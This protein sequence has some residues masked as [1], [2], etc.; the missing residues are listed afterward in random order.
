MKISEIN[1]KVL[2]IIPARKG[3][4]RI[5]NKNTK[6]FNNVPVIAYSINAAKK[7]KVF[8]YISVST[9]CKKIAKIAKRYGANVDFIRPR[10][11]SNDKA[12]TLEVIKHSIKFYENKG[13]KFDYI[14]C[15]YPSSPFTKPK[16]IKKVLNLLKK[17]STNFVFTAQQF[18]SPIQ[19]AISI[20]NNK[21][22]WVNK[23]YSSKNSN[24]LKKNYFD[25]GQFYFGTRKKF[26][27]KDNLIDNKTF[28]IILEKHSSIDI[29]DAQDW[30][31]AEK[32]SKI[33]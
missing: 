1:N 22:K 28:A 32:I 25:C 13:K 30:L 24:E 12:K 7:S 16:N 26:F 18:N 2:A 8:D 3:S 31:F 15:I 17:K 33:N 19:R 4:K 11:I 23:F 14:C 21:V 6:K 20:E 10:K 9:D 29:N 5:I 27:S